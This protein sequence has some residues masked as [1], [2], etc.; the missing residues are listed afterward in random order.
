MLFVGL[1]QWMAYQ[2]ISIPFYGNVKSKRP[3]FFIGLV[4]VEGKCA[5]ASTATATAIAIA[6]VVAISFENSK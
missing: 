4:L 1:V 3:F 6:T 2:F 5:D